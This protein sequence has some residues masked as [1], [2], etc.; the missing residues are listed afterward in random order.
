MVLVSK[1]SPLPARTAWIGDIFN[2]VSRALSGENNGL[3]DV[4]SVTSSADE[5]WVFVLRVGVLGKVLVVMS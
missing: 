5:C 3:F 4:G 1:P 2:G